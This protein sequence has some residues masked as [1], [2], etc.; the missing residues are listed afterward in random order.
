MEIES[1]VKKQVGKTNVLKEHNKSP[2]EWDYSDADISQLIK[3]YSSH[4]IDE[5]IKSKETE[6]D[7]PP[8]FSKS[9]KCRNKMSNHFSKFSDHLLILL[10]PLTVEFLQQAPHLNTQ[11]SLIRSTFLKCRLMIMLEKIPLILHT[12]CKVTKAIQSYQDHLKA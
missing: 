4:K 11:Q 5:K 2:V 7:P 6:I 1:A 9:D 8:G 12:C 3:S 10:L